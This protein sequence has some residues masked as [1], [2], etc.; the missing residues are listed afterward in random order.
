MKV[1]VRYLGQTYGWGWG[2]QLTN[3]DLFGF[4][5]VGCYCVYKPARGWGWINI[6]T[7]LSRSPPGHMFLYRKL[8][9]S[10]N[11]SGKVLRAQTASKY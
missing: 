9:S 6:E 7:P 11:E 10:K 4:S 2:V 1:N 5:C 8:E 3:I